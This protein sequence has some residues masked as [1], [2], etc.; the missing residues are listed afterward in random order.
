M[1]I[2]ILKIYTPQD[3]KA[4]QSINFIKSGDRYYLMSDGG[5]INAFKTKEEAQDCFG[6][7]EYHQRDHTWSAS[8]CVHWMQY[9]PVIYEIDS[10]EDIQEKF[11]KGQKKFQSYQLGSIAGRVGGIE[12]ESLELAKKRYSEGETVEL[13]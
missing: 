1:F 8:A 2:I 6:Y 10:V 7:K 4:E 9:S 13:I 5:A 11:L 3:E 12:I